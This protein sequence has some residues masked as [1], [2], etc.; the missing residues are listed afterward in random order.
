MKTYSRSLECRSLKCPSARRINVFL[1][2][3][4]MGLSAMSEFK[5]RER[6]HIVSFF[7]SSLVGQM[8]AQMTCDVF[9]TLR[10]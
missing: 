2:T 6:L 3:K 1:R 5:T 4:V 8:V 9:V 7:K 10:V